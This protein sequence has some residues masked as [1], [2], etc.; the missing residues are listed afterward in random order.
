MATGCGASGQDDNIPSLLCLS[1]LPVLLCRLMGRP[2]HRHS[3]VLG[4]RR[5]RPWAP[6]RLA[7]RTAVRCRPATLRWVLGPA[8]RIRAE[9]RHLSSVCAGRRSSRQRRCSHAD[10][11]AARSWTGRPPLRAQ[12]PA[13][14]A[15]LIGREPAA[16]SSCSCGMAA[17][18]AGAAQREGSE[19]PLRRASISGIAHEW[20]ANGGR[21]APD[22]EQ[23]NTGSRRC[24]IVFSRSRNC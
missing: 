9:C 24:L 6:P 23:G 1:L 10:A 3:G 13:G 14:A 7:S 4:Q 17:G 12:P 15:A 2:G 20:R 16:A 21:V 19:Q 18:D 11:S 5:P 8:R 22:P